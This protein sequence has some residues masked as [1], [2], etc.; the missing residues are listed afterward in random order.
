MPV[1]NNSRPRR[2]AYNNPFAAVGIAAGISFLYA[3][4]R[5]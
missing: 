3:M 4:I 2:T 1:E 5:G